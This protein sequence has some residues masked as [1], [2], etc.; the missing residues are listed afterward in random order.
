MREWPRWVGFLGAVAF[1][2]VGAQWGSMNAGWFG[3]ERDAGNLQAWMGV[4]VAVVVVAFASC[5]WGRSLLESGAPGVAA[6]ILLVLAPL[7]H[8]VSALIE[9]AIVGTLALALG[10][11]LLTITVFR[12][13]LM[14]L[15]E[16]VVVA[17]SAV[18]SFTWNTETASV[19]LLVAI[20][21][22]WAF[23]SF[24]LLPRSVAAPR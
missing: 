16:R 17:L 19:W 22:G 14:P 8:M 1:A 2:A 11:I 23:L 21:I 13:R 12:R 18:A 4:A 7:L 10:L 6:A 24:R 3:L 9:F 5:G 15:T 20:G